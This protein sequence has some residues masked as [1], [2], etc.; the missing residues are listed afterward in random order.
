VTLGFGGKGGGRGNHP[1]QKVFGGNVCQNGGLGG[2]G[3]KKIEMVTLKPQKKG[4]GEKKRVSPI[5]GTGSGQGGLALFQRGR[6][7]GKN[8][9]A[10]GVPFLKTRKGAARENNL[11]P[12]K[13]KKKEEI[14][15]VF[16]EKKKKKC[17]KLCNRLY[18]RGVP[19][20]KAG[21]LQL[22]DKKKKPAPPY[23]GKKGFLPVIERARFPP[24]KRKRKQTPNFA[25]PSTKKKR[26][27]GGPQAGKPPPTSISPIHEKREKQ[28]KAFPPGF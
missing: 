22:G 26:R 14:L 5:F 10:W 3:K 23:P 4:G 2:G 6:E 27:K 16:G 28:W 17:T 20:P 1:C 7:G 18:K 11:L 21:P 12:Q 19:Q 9:L 8:V 15:F 25:S 13:K 24:E